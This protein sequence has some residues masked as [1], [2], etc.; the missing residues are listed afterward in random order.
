M[1]L[2]LAGGEGRP[3]PAVD[4][5]GPCLQLETAAP[6][7]ERGSAELRAQRC[8]PGQETAL[9]SGKGHPQLCGRLAESLGSQ[10]SLSPSSLTSWCKASHD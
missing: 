7:R 6:G 1:F 9:C 4:R 8:G 3:S 2:A 10:P 5:R